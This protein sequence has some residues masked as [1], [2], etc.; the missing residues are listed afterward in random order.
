MSAGVVVVLVVLALVVVG[1]ALVW[2]WSADR[3]DHR[4]YLK[5][6]SAWGPDGVLAAGQAWEPIAGDGPPA[7]R[8][9][10]RGVTA[11]A[12]NPTG[13]DHEQPSNP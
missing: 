6:W 7:M 10:T 12:G 11:E 4:R 1:L 8:V 3:R 13:A 2:A 9:R 5:D